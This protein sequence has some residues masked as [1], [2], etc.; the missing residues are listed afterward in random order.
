MPLLFA[1]VPALVPCPSASLP[2][3]VVALALV[4]CPSASA[5]ACHRR[6]RRHLSLACQRP[7]LPLLSRRL[8]SLACQRP[9][10]PAVVVVA[11]ATNGSGR[12]RQIVAVCCC[13][14]RLATA[15]AVP[16][17]SVV[18]CRHNHCCH[19]ALFAAT[20]AAK[21]PTFGAKYLFTHREIIS[22]GSKKQKSS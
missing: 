16:S 6:C 12:A 22:P 18:Q 9:P 3:V 4:P 13:P 8:S 15:L 21:S 1:A 20:A 10:L 2:D 17:T 11:A 19:Q 14:C 5:L 7:C